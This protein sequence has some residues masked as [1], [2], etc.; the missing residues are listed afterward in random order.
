M[1]STYSSTL[2]S[3]TPP[4]SSKKSNTSTA[5]LTTSSSK[6][7]SLR[8]KLFLQSIEQ[9]GW[10]CLDTGGIYLFWII[11]HYSSAHLYTYWCTPTTTMGFI[12]SPLMVPTPQCQAIRWVLIHGSSV[13]DNMWLLLS[14]WFTSKLIFC[15]IK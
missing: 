3:S 1:T 13:I 7:R 11:M 8:S 4:S 2:H 5:L 15:K 14:S 6:K 12:L 9:F 10:I